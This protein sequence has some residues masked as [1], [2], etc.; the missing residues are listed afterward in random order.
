V[1]IGDIIVG[2]ATAFEVLV[3]V[4]VNVAVLLFFAWLGLR[5]PSSEK[6]ILRPT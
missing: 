5:L 1:L 4:A 3:S 2:Q 6:V